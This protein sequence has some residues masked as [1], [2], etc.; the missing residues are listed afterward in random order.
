MMRKLSIGILA[1]VLL[2]V[3]ALVGF[4]LTRGRPV[5]S[6]PRDLPPTKADFRV[7]EVHLQEEGSDKVLW[8][9]DADQ[10]EV[11]EREGKT[12]LRGVTITIQEPDRTW[13]VTGEEGDLVQATKDVSIRKNVVLVSSDGIRLETDSLR[14]HA[15]DK[16]VWTDSPVTL[17]RSG[18][19]IRG[20]GLEARLAEE[21]TSVKGRVRV[22]FTQ[23]RSEPPSP[24][25]ADRSHA[26]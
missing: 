25:V 2:F 21:R 8:K 17:Y 19:V 7:K 18:A 15:K 6:D 26:R 14:W 24:P 11:F 20:Q 12:L 10:A 5:P 3:L 1:G 13:N 4:L 22:T 16:R 23:T 9:L